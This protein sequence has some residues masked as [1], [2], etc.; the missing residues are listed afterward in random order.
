M[1]KPIK[2]PICCCGRMHKQSWRLKKRIHIEN[3]K[4]AERE[5]SV[6]CNVC[7]RGIDSFYRYE[8]ILK[9]NWPAESN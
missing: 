3:G 4:Y 2:L 8:D 1:G 6:F 7:G 5:Y 9:H